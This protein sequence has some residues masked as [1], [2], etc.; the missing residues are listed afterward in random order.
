MKLYIEFI[1]L[2]FKKYIVGFSTGKVLKDFSEKMGIAYIKFAQILATQNYGNL[3]TERD[4]QILSSICDNINPISYDKIYKM[5]Q[6][7]YNNGIDTIF[8]YIDPRPIGSASISQV[9]K[10]VLK[11]GE[12]VA[13]KVK[14]I[15][16][17][18]NIN[19]DV[20]TIKKLIHRY[21]KFFKFK[22]YI[23]G[24]NA[25]NLY[26][27][28]IYEET[29]FKHEI[30]NIKTYQEF[31]N[32]V[33]GKVENTVDIKVPKLYEELCTENIIVME[34]I[35]H[36]TINKMELTEENKEKISVGI[37]SYFKLSF[38]ALF[39]DKKIVFHGDPHSGNIYLDDNN[40]IGF[41]DMGLLFIIN[42]EEAKLLRKFFLTAYSGNYEKLYNMLIKYGVMNEE[43]KFKFREDCLKFCSEIK[44]KDVTCYFM[45]MVVMEWLVLLNQLLN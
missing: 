7:E 38:Y 26:L 43:T 4:R 40:N 3:F 10:A 20:N 29:D 15:D 34:F 22:N 42:E 37:N 1:K 11:S 31:A 18:K 24:D 39:N 23:A 12:V 32:E 17:T 28:W 36:K 35:E 8:S 19:K 2:L 27:N 5:L 30:E 45:D 13:I 6:K 9:H 14:R 21:G 33:N 16:I 44:D 25:L 41:L